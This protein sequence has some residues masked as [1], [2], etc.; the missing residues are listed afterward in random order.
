MIT[1]EVSGG[2]GNQMFRYAFGYAMAKK[3]HQPLCIDTAVSEH[4]DFRSYELDEFCVEYAKRMTYH[5]GTRPWDRLFLNRLCRKA[6]LGTHTVLSQGS[7]AYYYK[8][9]IEQSIGTTGDW[10]LAGNWINYRYFSEERNA[11]RTV[12][13]PR[14]KDPEVEALAK[15]FQASESVAIHVRRSDYI[16]LGVALDEAYYKEAVCRMREMHRGEKADFYVFSDDAEYCKEL[17]AN[18]DRFHFPE[19]A[20]SHKS[21]YDLYLMSR[22]KNLIIANSTYS[23]WSAYLAADDANVIAPVSGIWQEDFYLKEWQKI[24]V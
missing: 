13:S 14:V 20:S 12:F 6:V 15:T 3:Y 19:Y 1:V 5:Q 11:L 24:C 22:C 23:W 8:P 7:D 17:F 9:E 18:E 16:K 21:V 10:Y 4:I 2:L